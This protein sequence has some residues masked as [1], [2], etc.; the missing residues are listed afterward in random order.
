MNSYVTDI[1][2][3]V[4]KKSLLEYFSVFDKEKIS[5]I[6]NSYTKDFSSNL[7]ENK[8][9]W[10][11]EQVVKKIELNSLSALTEEATRN[12]SELLLLRKD[13]LLNLLNH[14]DLCKKD[15][16]EKMPDVVLKEYEDDSVYLGMINENNKRSGIGYF[17]EHDK[18]YIFFGDWKEDFHQKGILIL[19]K[20]R[21]IE[22]F[23]GTFELEEDVIFNFDGFFLPV[24]SNPEEHNENNSLSFAYGKFIN[25]RKT[26][27]GVM[28]YS[29]NSSKDF[30]VYI[31]KLTEFKK[32][33]ENG[34]LINYF[35]NES[36]IYKGQF[37]SDSKLNDGVMLKPHSYLFELKYSKDGTLSESKSVFLKLNDESIF[38]GKIVLQGA[39][40]LN[41][42]SSGIVL[43]K[44][45]HIYIGSFLK[46]KKHGNGEYM[47]RNESNSILFMYIAEFID[48]KIANGKIFKLNDNINF[49]VYEGGFN[50]N[51]PSQGKYYYENNEC[52]EGEF[53]NNMRQGKGR[54]DYLDKC[55]YEG[56][57]KNNNKHGRGL[58]VDN[59]NN[60]FES[61][62][63][64]N[65]F[66]NIES[67]IPAEENKN[68]VDINKIMDESDKAYN[69]VDNYESKIN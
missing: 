62:W 68:M 43:F 12:C 5:Q 9:I 35:N 61:N 64:N 10:S 7:E 33:D 8:N 11:Y 41:L 22:I 19:A 4:F 6:I 42:G 65:N 69:P 32:N 31:G 66:I 46:G 1:I 58:Y 2:S 44:N 15:H 51:L 53:W 21:V 47:I 37:V 23:I 59:E 63:N 20:E 25:H 55:Y 60:A 13:L 40:T 56:E 38:N 36:I 24:L 18:S 39:N 50:D 17:A 49:T 26:V 29:C 34:I 52:Y 30:D 14:I 54:Y 28:V 48:D 27:E 67:S 45:N 3:S 16:L 57:W